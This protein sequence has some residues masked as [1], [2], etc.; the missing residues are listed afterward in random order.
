MGASSVCSSGLIVGAKA[1]DSHP[2][3]PSEGEAARGGITVQPV[4]HDNAIEIS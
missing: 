4:A 2:G 3:P 1:T